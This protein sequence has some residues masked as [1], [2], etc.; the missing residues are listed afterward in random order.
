MNV[1]KIF[2]KKNYNSNNNKINEINTLHR[3][4]IYID[5]SGL[6]DFFSSP[7]FD[8]FFSLCAFVLFAKKKIRNNKKEISNEKK[9]I[10]KK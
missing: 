8:V 4:A 9:V 6:T 2:K 3:D 1:L 10:I 5:I 7:F